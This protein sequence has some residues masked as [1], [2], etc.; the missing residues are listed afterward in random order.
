MG[1]PCFIQHQTEEGKVELECAPDSTDNFQIVCPQFEMEGELWHSVEQCYQALKFE[2]GSARYVQIRDTKPTADLEHPRFKRLKPQDAMRAVSA[3]HG[4]DVWGQARGEQEGS[5]EE[6]EAVKL[7]VMLRAN[8][9]KYASSKQLQDDLM[10]TGSARLVGAT[11]TWNWP[12]WNGLIQIFIRRALN[13]G[14]DLREIVALCDADATR[15]LEDFDS[16]LS[17]A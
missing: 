17:T 3:E 10:A 1:G 13:E 9:A 4:F 12:K 11:S 15:I 16:R 6:F 5:R 14:R 2:K 8:C 7:G